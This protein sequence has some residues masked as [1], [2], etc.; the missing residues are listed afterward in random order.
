MLVESRLRQ[1]AGQ[2]GL[3]PPRL[4]KQAATLGVMC[5]MGQWLFVPGALELLDLFAERFRTC[6]TYSFCSPA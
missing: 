3:R 6:H 5:L 1:L 2:A 4:L